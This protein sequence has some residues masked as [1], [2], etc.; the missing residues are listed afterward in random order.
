MRTL[1][2]AVALAGAV[3]ATAD[4][5]SP[6]APRAMMASG[7]VTAQ[8]QPCITLRIHFPQDGTSREISTREG[9]A[10]AQLQLQHGEEYRDFYLDLTV[11]D[12]P[13]GMVHV[14]IRVDRNSDPIDQFDLRV[15]EGSIQATTTPPFSLS[16]LR[17]FDG[18]GPTCRTQ[19]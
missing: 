8:S 15:G 13:S 1:L 19:A 11:R 5:Q 10:T 18:M 9:A 12:R 7:A 2:T 16:V 17:I 3:T 6:A 14:S 4:V